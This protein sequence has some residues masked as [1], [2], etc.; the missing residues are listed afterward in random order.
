MSLFRSAR[1][2]IASTSVFFEAEIASAVELEEPVGGASPWRDFL[3]AHGEGIHHL[4]FDVGAL[5]D[6]VELLEAKGGTRVLGES[7]E[8]HAMVD[9]MT[10]FGLYFELT[11][12]STPPPLGTPGPPRAFANSPESYRLATDR[13]WLLE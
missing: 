4:G 7:G 3:D 11:E 12:T 1:L 2:S 5:D 13:G 10:R 6:H 8:I 9:L